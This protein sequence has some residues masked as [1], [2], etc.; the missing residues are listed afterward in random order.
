MPTKDIKPHATQVIK[1]F[2]YYCFAC[3]NP[4]VYAA[5]PFKFEYVIC[6]NCGKPHDGSNYRE[7][8][9]LPMS[10]QEIQEVNLL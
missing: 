8:N 6:P 2:R 9:W 3:T 5:S 1:R 10:D 4:A 7:D